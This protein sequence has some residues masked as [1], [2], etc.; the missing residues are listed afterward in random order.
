MPSN[1]AIFVFIFII[2]IVLDLLILIWYRINRQRLK[3]WLE[4]RGRSLKGFNTQTLAWFKQK[5]KSDNPQAGDL[6]VQAAGKQIGSGDNAIASQP[7]VAVENNNSSVIPDKLKKKQF[8]GGYWLEWLI[9][10]LGVTL[11]CAG[12]LDLR[13]PTRLPGNESEVFQMLDW[14]L[15]NSLKQYHAFPLWNIYIQSGLPYVADPML[16]VY[17]PVVTV[18]VLL[19]GVR[20]GFKLGVY[21]SFLIAALGMW[22]L[23]LTLVDC[24]DVCLCRSTGGALFPRPI[25]VCS[26]VCLYSL[27]YFQPGFGHPT[28]ASTGYCDCSSFS[29][30]AFF[31]R[32][33]ILPFLHVAHPWCVW[34]NNVAAS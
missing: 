25:P 7:L 28:S 31:L 16:H 10:F 1:L 34:A 13:A 8:W 4:G 2:A 9:I 32:Q 27:D 29:W 6:G 22:R 12:I 26:W 33:C 23:A 15:V 3:K 20:A 17:N 14:T 5:I 11:F 30:V 18:P 21:F 19:F 24:A